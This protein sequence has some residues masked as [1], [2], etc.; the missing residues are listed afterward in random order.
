M[1]GRRAPLNPDRSLDP[2]TPAAL[3]LLE[4]VVRRIAHAELMPRFGASGSRVKD[5]GSLVTAADTA[6]QSCLAEELAAYWPDVQLMGEE[7]TEE[8]QYASLQCQA[9]TWCLDPLDGTTNFVNGV[10]FF[11]VSLALLRD[12]KPV[13]G[14][15]YDP[16]RQECF[17]A[18]HGQGA[19]LNGQPIK[20][21]VPA[22]ALRCCVAIVD[23]K[24]LR[25]RLAG[26]LGVDPPYRSQRSYGSCALDWCWLAVGRAH[27]YLHGGQKL[28]DYAAGSLILQEVGGV[29]ASLDGDPMTYETLGPAS[30][31]AARTPDLY[32]AWRAWITHNA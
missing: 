11:A 24:R 2:C 19:W 6:V 23:F 32:E 5:D 12:N 9:G 22:P 18:L 17:S 29:F 10:P 15:V 13:L 4:D 20:V 26:R 25:P 7:M 21:R 31:V 27:L 3:Q 1:E 16:S 30:A 28:W 14:L 8:M